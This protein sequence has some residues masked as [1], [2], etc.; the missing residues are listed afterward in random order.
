VARGSSGSLS[1]TLDA[2]SGP[3]EGADLGVS[4]SYTLG[5]YSEP[6][7]AERML[8]KDHLQEGKTMSLS[9]KHL[10]STE[11]KQRLLWCMAVQAQGLSGALQFDTSAISVKATDEPNDIRPLSRGYS[12]AC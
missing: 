2:E 4:Y 12:M 7:C 5:G 1:R 9:I 8:D 10:I 6:A 11:T 3:L